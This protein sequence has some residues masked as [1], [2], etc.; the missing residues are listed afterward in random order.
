MTDERREAF[1]GKPLTAQDF[2]DFADSMTKRW[3]PERQK[4]KEIAAPRWFMKMIRE[5]FTQT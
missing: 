3:P 5:T 1:E 4:P 2:V